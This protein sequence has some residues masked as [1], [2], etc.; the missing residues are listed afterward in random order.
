MANEEFPAINWLGYS[1]DMTAPL[2]MTIR[3][4]CLFLRKYLEDKTLK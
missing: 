3:A 2:P 4:V 1:I